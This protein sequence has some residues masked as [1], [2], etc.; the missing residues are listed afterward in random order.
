MSLFRKKVVPAGGMTRERSLSFVPVRNLAVREET[1]AE[2]LVRLTYPV[3]VRPAFSGMLK[4]LGIWDG[5]PSQKT[6][7]LDAMGCATWEL[8]DGTRC[9]REVAQAFAAR[10]RL[11]EREAEVAVA[12]FLR[13]LGRRGAV[14]F[15]EPAADQGPETGAPGT[16]QAG[17]GQD[18][19]D[20]GV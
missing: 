3:T 16:L 17:I 11:G 14:G 4:R 5:R 2:G 1:T 15:R 13:E 6:I 12:A 10:Y 7:E 18:G 20:Q 8:V 19:G 9:V